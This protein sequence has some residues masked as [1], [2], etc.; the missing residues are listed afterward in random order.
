M[1]TLSIV[2]VGE[3]VT[4]HVLVDGR[5][6]ETVKVDSHLSLAEAKELVGEVYGHDFQLRERQYGMIESR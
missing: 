2:R 5:Q 6:V 4:A 1:V 3:T